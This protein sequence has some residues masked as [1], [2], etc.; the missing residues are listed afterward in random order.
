MEIIYLEFWKTFDS[1]TQYFC[2]QLTYV[3]DEWAARWV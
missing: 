3:L 2:I 1:L